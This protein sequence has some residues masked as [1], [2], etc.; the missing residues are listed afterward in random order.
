MQVGERYLAV[1]ILYEGVIGLHPLQSTAEI[2]EV[3]AASE[4]DL[5]AEGKEIAYRSKITARVSA[6]IR[7]LRR[8]IERSAAADNNSAHRLPRV[9]PARQV[10]RRAAIEIKARP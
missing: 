10:R 7:D 1:L 3:A 8:S 5:I 2:D 6:A 9:Y 4:G